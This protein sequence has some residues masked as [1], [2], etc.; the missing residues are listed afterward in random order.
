LPSDY[1]PLMHIYPLSD[2]R[3]CIPMGSRRVM[4]VQQHDSDNANL[5]SM[6]LGKLVAGEFDDIT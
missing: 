6:I 1:S 5:A 3:R 4:G 2:G